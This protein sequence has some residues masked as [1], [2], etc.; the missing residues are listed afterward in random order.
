MW[1]ER[2]RPVIEQREF[3]VSEPT[4]GAP[5]AAHEGNRSNGPA[6]AALVTGI[7]ALLLSW[8]PGIN[9][10]AFVLAIAAL[11]T[12]FI[13]LKH[14]GRPDTGGRGM[15]ITGLV[16]GV[17]A[18]I[19]GVGVYFLAANFISNNPEIQEEIE[20]QQQQQNG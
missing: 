10:V 7:I 11:I 9:L 1:Y 4:Y 8:I 12:G 20:R 3:D 14:A 13:G 2:T 18:I 17:L 5:P 15:A 19:V 6:I 16:T